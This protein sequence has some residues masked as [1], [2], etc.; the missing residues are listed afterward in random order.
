MNR[1][2]LSA[3]EILDENNIGTITYKHLYLLETYRRTRY[4][5]GEED[6]EGPLRPDP[7]QKLTHDDVANILEK[8]LKAGL[9]VWI[10]FRSQIY[11]LIRKKL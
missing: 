3:C 10:N 1:A 9:P 8:A 5:E 4:E 7:L 11:I 6:E 2:M